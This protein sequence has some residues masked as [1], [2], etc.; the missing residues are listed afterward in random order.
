MTRYVA[1]GLI[2]LSFVAYL[3]YEVKK[4]TTPPNLE[5]FEPADETIVKSPILIIS[6]VSEK[7]TRIKINGEPVMSNT[8]GTF[9]EDI[10]LQ[11]GLNIIKI[12]A[13][14]KYSKENIIYRKIIF[15]ET[16]NK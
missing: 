13:A 7:E 10:D 11:R 16:K 12:S 2:I 8:D 3:G 5:I 9:K 4:I 1:L 15:D 14:K 6:G